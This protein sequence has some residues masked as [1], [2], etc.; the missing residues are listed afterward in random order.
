MAKDACYA[1]SCACICEEFRILRE[2]K[3]DWANAHKPRLLDIK[4]CSWMA[5]ESSVYKALI[6][7]IGLESPGFS[8]LRVNIPLYN[9]SFMWKDIR[10]HQTVYQWG[11]IPPVR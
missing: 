3:Q 6:F 9:A 7:F 1:H 5:K 10:G 2:Y 11:K 4:N 8:M